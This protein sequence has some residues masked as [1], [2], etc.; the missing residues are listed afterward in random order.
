MDSD[1]WKQVD[2]L[3]QSALDRPPEEAGR[4]SSPLM[5]HRRNPGTRSSLS[6]G[7]AAAGRE[8]P[9]ES[10]DRGGRA[11]SGRASKAETTQEST[12][13]LAGQTLSRYRILGEAG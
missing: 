9:G 3:L 10:R 13:F 6:A 12:D 7:G 2:S 5:R 1:R 4:V 11:A 8:L